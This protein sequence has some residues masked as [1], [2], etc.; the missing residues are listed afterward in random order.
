MMMKSSHI[1]QDMPEH[2]K[3]MAAFFKNMSVLS[4]TFVAITVALSSNYFQTQSYD[5]LLNIALVMFIATSIA[6]VNAQ[7]A[8]A[9]VFRVPELLTGSRYGKL[10]A[11]TA[12]PLIGFFSGA[13]LCVGYV[14]F[15]LVN[16][17]LS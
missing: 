3:Q 6:S 14:I 1:E 8:Y 15:Q 16:C 4:M 5:W 13:V 7:L 17:Y 2:Y 11:S 9:E 12:K 10:A